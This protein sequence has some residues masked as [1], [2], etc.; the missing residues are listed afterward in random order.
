ML[1]KYREKL[2]CSQ[3]GGKSD[4]FSCLTSVYECEHAHAKRVLTAKADAG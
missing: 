4:D 3:M 2:L 1:C